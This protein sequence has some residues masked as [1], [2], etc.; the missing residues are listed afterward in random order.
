M[1]PLIL[2]QAVTPFLPLI[3]KVV[4]AKKTGKSVVDTIKASTGGTEAGQVGVISALFLAYQDVI[5]CNPVF[6]LASLSCVTN[7]HIGALVIASVF[8]FTQ[9]LRK[10]NTND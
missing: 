6:S 4:D 5:A 10:A 8:A 7:E 2:L 9:L 1:N 3:T